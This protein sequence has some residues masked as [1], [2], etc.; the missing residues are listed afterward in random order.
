MRFNWLSSQH[1]Y[2]S[3]CLWVTEIQGKRERKTG[4]GTCRNNCYSSDSLPVK[5][6]ELYKPS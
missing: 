1:G 4:T 3:T 2:Y 5:F 6:P